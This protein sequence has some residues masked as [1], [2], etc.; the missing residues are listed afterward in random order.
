MK[1]YKTLKKTEDIGRNSSYVHG[2]AEL[3][4]GKELNYK[5]HSTDCS[6]LHKNTNVTIYKNRTIN[7]RIH[8]KPQKT[9]NSQSNLEEKE[10][11]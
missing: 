10:Q 3:I 11:C 7:P 4:L 6:N 5:K 9:P 1:R 8:M 2:F